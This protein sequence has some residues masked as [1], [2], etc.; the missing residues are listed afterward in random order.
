M[1]YS[2]HEAVRQAWEKAGSI[3]LP[4]GKIQQLNRIIDDDDTAHHPIYDKVFEQLDATGF[5]AIPPASVKKVLIAI[6]KGEIYRDK[7]LWTAYRSTPAQRGSYRSSAEY[8]RERK[9]RLRAMGLCECAKRPPEP[10]KTRCRVCLDKYRDAQNRYNN[11]IR[12][13]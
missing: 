9:Q 5:T 13:G 11:K 6:H 4:K 2:T 1:R 3:M 12:T 7:Y 8:T 10:G